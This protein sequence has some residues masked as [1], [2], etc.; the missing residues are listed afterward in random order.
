MGETATQEINETITAE[1]TQRITLEEVERQTIVHCNCGDVYAYRVW[2]STFLIEQ[3]SGNRL[4]LLNIFNITYAPDWTINNGQGFTL[5]FEGLSKDCKMFDL[6]E[7][8]DE[9]GGFEVKGIQR[10]KT[11]VYNVKL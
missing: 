7:I 1:S 6:M 5:V 3:E 9:P 8:I 10:N 4:R 2:P 11:D